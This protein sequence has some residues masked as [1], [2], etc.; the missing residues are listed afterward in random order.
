MTCSND[1]VCS[2]SNGQGRD[3]LNL[4]A[5]YSCCLLPE[6]C[7]EEFNVFLDRGTIVGTYDHR[8][9]GFFSEMAWGKDVARKSTQKRVNTQAV[10]SDAETEQRCAL[11]F[12]NG[13]DV[14]DS[15][16]KDIWENLLQWSGNDTENRLLKDLID[17]NGWFTG[18]EK[19]FQDAFFKVTGRNISKTFGCSLLW[20]KS[21][22]AFFTEDQKEDYKE[23]LKTDW[24]CFYS[25]DPQLNAKQIA[26]GIKEAR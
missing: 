9:I 16:Y 14:R 17:N 7:C 12:E 6:T 1:P 15:S 25:C 26:D 22:A 20:K 11:I 3:S 21:K 19:P 18:K 24:I 4:S 23:A 5:C 8:D 10:S 2:L 13:T